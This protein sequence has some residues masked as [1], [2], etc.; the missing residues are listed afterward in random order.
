VPTGAQLIFAARMGDAPE[1]VVRAMERRLTQEKSYVT[2]DMLL[3]DLGDLDR[4]GGRAAA[5]PFLA[6]AFDRPS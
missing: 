1:W 2:L 6:F 4:P 5:A 3:A